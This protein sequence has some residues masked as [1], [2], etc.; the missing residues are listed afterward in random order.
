[1]KP[2]VVIVD[3]EIDNVHNFQG[4]F[5]DVFE[6]VPA[7]IKE[8]FDEMV[9]YLLNLNADGYVF[10]YRFTDTMPNVKYT[11][12]ELYNHIIDSKHEIPVILLTGQEDKM[13]HKIYDPYHII[14]KDSFT[15]HTELFKSKLVQIVSDYKKNVDAR[16]KRLKELVEKRQ[17]QS[18]KIEEEVELIELDTYLDKVIYKKDVIPEE[19]K[20]SQIDGRLD[21]LL[22][23]TQKILDG[24][25]KK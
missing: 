12:A 7:E 16:S 9:L 4:E 20:K 11:G 24:L 13:E 21:K 23:N 17:K 6:V 8:D 25:V 14:S 1:M 22:E 3:N 2:K 10:D 5:D 18:L 15:S 19:L